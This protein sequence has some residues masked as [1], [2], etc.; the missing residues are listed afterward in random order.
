MIDGG[1]MKVQNMFC[2][3]YQLIIQSDK[4]GRT[5][6]SSLLAC[7]VVDNWHAQPSHHHRKSTLV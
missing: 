4:S 7:S 5:S 6:E 1:T 2:T 3:P